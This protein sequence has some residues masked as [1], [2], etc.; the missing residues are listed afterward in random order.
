VLNE[1]AASTAGTDWEFV[2]LLGDAGLS[3]DGVALLQLDGDGAVRSVLDFTGLSLGDNGYAL[4]TSPTAEQVFGLTG[5]LQFGDN[6]FT[7]TASTFL[8]VEGY[9][10]VAQFTDLDTDDDGVLDVTPFA[11]V[12][13]AVALTDTGSP[14]I[15][16]GAAVVG[17]DG[18]FLPAGAVRL[19]EGSGDWQITDFGDSDSY[20]PTAASAGAQ[21]VINEIDSDT[22]GTDAAEFIEL[23]DGGA[24]GTALDGLSLVLFNGNGDTAY[25]VIDLT[26]FS[27]DENGYFVAG[28]ADVAN[29]DLVA[30]TT[31]GLQNGADAVALVQGDAAALS[32]IAAADLDPASV[33]DA[34][35]YGTADP[36]D[37]ELLAAFGETIQV[38]ED[39]NGDKDT[40]SLSRLPNGE[41]DFTAQAPTP[42]AANDAG[43]TEPG[44]PTLISAIQGS[45]ADSPLAGQTVTVTAIV[46][47]DFQDGDADTL[48]DLRGFFLTEEA[49]DQDGDAA[50]S[51]GLRVFEG[52][53]TFLT[54][55]NIGDRV[56]VTGT[57]TEYFGET[58]LNATSVELVEA[59]AVADVMSLAVS[60]SLDAIDAVTTSQDGDYI[61]DLE[62]YEG[63]LVTFT[64]TLTVAEMFQMDR[65]NEIGLSAN[66]RPQ[67]YTQF[68]EPDVAGYESYLRQ[69]GSDR[70]FFDD[71]LNRQNAA[72]LPEADL[73]GDGVF[74]TADGFSMGDTITGLTGVL[75]YDWAGN[76]ASGA[77]WRVRSVDDGNVFEDTGTRPDTPPDVGGSITVTSFNVLNFFTTLVGEGTSGPGGLNPR[78]ANTVEEYER[79]LDKL[80]T[81]L[82]A[83]DADLFGLVELEN[84]FQTDQNGDGEVAIQSLVDAM[85]AEYG[86][87]VW[88]YVDPGRPFVDTSDAISVGMIYRTDTLAYDPASVRILDDSQ[89]DGLGFGALDDDGL[90]VFDGPSTN[91]A[92]MAATFTDPFTGED[93]TFA[94]T[95]MKSK[96]GSGTGDNADAGDGAGNFDAL[97]TEGVTVL[98]AWLDSFADEDVLV[99]GDFNAY[100]QENPI[101]AMLAAGY[102]NLEQVFDPG[103]DSFV[104]DGY[105]GTLDYG[106]ANDT[107]MDKV[108]GAAIWEINSPEPDAIDYNLDFGR[109]PAIFDGD[110][111]WRASDHDPLLIGLDFLPD[112]ELA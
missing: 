62:A 74:D 10:G 23:F 18:S 97:R 65:F 98:N 95:H 17:P 81:T 9:S 39:A 37:A 19:P 68:A 75:T 53:G 42:G 61:P 89:L 83:I 45:G 30:F 1:I 16:E 67:Q 2:E 66:G 51:E 86:S 60:L 101:D 47:G 46:T 15:Y 69:T 55:V 54:D 34:V 111:V 20:T 11:S 32:G 94:V 41:G 70:I 4:A 99:V 48:R 56:T 13:D 73:N 92:P 93:F 71:G 108:T 85:N 49:A 104:F 44:T 77:T 103:S 110:T 96:G 88:D 112:L 52:T 29:V 79:Q 91:R 35:V 72:I 6:T 5:D 7:N 12:I 8:L 58:Q 82:T 3:L 36:D 78:G 63:M 57:V 25:D 31:N 84:E 106:F 38:D 90:G 14:L 26:G 102:A 50:T 80:V 105:T 107:L 21:L 76:S 109:D 24:G 27:T 28:S 33:L 43:G 87:I 40:Q 100:A 59:G 64:D 22:P